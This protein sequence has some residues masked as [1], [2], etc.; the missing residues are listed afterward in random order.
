[1]KK[2]L[3]T[4]YFISCILNVCA[5][6]TLMNINAKKEVSPTQKIATVENL[7]GNFYVDSV[8]EEKL[9]EEGIKAMLATLDPHSTYTNAEETKE[10][11][12]PLE[13]NFSGIGVQFSLVKD[14][15]YVIQTTVGGPSEKVGMLPGDRILSANDSILSGAGR[16]NN[17][18]L[19]ILRGPKGTEVT[20]EVLRRGVADPLQFRIIRDDIP[21]YSVDAAYKVN[22]STGY[23]KVSRFAGSTAREVQSALGKFREEGVK[24][25]I[26]DLEDNGG[27]YLDAAVNLASLFLPKGSLIVYTEG[28]KVGRTDYNVQDNPIWPDGKLIVLVN[29]NSASSSEIFAGAI[30]DHDRGAI[31]GR[32]T[33]GK[34][35]VQRPFPFPDGS[36]VRLTISKYF[37]PS[38]RSIQKPYEKGDTRDYYLDIYNRYQNGELMNADSVHFEDTLKVHT[39]N[40][41]RIV[42]GGGGIMPDVFVPIDTTGNTKYYRDI[43]AN[44][45]F[46]SFVISYIDS[47]RNELKKVYPTRESFIE[48]FSVTEDVLSE[49]IE[50]ADKAGI[51][52]DEEQLKESKELIVTIIKGLIGRDLWDLDTYYIVTNPII[53]PT[54][55]E[56]LQVLDSKDRYSSILSVEKTAQDSN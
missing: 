43:L 3:L 38:G 31:I 33:F 48:K 14:T 28:P 27:G 24:D 46:N 6:Q 13:G 15:L 40:K 50:H 42:Y 5:K 32:R 11:T 18:I 54:Y 36:M 37:T 1:M 52:P 2:I 19:N 29:Q 34:G 10:L 21:L 44:G 4:V 22:S 56:A 41:K 17:E 23:I 49:F 7:I 39:L 35:L 47:H 16:K 55:N 26:I 53:R 25:I 9:V 20:V 51:E 45:L 30:Q 8:D 12:T